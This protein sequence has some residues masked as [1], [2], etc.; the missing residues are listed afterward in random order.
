MLK[1][2]AILFLLRQRGVFKNLKPPLGKYIKYITMFR[3]FII[4][5]CIAVCLSACQ[6]NGNPFDPMF[7][8]RCHGANGVAPITTIIYGM[9]GFRQDMDHPGEYTISPELY[10]LKYMEGYFPVKEGRI[11]IEV[12]EDGKVHV[13]A[14]ED[15]TVKVL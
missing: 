6:M 9:F 5:C 4:G 3:D 11:S 12:D 7:D 8:S 15:C 2:A 14:P 13:D 10:N 1:M